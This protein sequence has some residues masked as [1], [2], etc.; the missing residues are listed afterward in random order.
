MRRPGTAWFCPGTGRKKSS[1]YRNFQYFSYR[2]WDGA[3]ARMIF[4]LRHYRHLSGTETCDLGTIQLWHSI[5]EITRDR[6]QV[7]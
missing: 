3:R 6:R 1:K 4:W 7:F 5:D 2:V